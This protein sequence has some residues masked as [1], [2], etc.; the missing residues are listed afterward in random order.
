MA[1]SQVQNAALS[2][3]QNETEY[4]TTCKMFFIIGKT[5]PLLQYGSFIFRI[6]PEYF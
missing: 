2:K 6:F 5:G 3:E 1:T 4:E